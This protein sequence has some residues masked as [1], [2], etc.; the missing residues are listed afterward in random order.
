MQVYTHNYEN[1]RL[2]A[3]ELMD[4]W[5]AAVYDT[6]TRTFPF[7]HY[8]LGNDPDSTK[9]EAIRDAEAYL[10]RTLPRSIPMD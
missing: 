9:E 2:Y 3:E 7:K 4:G 10:G 8:S 1:L 6:E 5:I